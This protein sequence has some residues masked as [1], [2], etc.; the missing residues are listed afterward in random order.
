MTQKAAIAKF[1]DLKATTVQYTPQVSKRTSEAFASS[2]AKYYPA[3][4]NLASK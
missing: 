2:A 1:K 4:K 3:L